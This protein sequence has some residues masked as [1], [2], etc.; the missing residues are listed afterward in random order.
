MKTTSIVTSL[1]VT[2]VM[3]VYSTIAQADEKTET[4]VV[5][6][7]AWVAMVD[8]K[9]YKKSWQEAA[10]YFK[11]IVKEEKWEEM[12]AA[13]RNPLGKAESR[14]LIAAEYKTS[15]PG[16]P[17]GEYVVIQFKT[18]FTGK[19]DSVETITPMK[20]EGVWRVSGY[21]IK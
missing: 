11:E 10:P 8:A 5:V 21:F 13:V 19:R 7:K 3:A 12:I 15:L 2:C 18:K 17:D 4:A 16:V 6:A 20:T 9:E 1:V 14:E